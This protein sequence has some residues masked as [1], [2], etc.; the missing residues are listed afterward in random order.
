MNRDSVTLILIENQPRNTEKLPKYGYSSFIITKEE[1][2]SVAYASSAAYAV[3]E[4]GT[5]P[6]GRK[7]TYMWPFHNFWR[8][9]SS[10]N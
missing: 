8:S 6:F 9:S 1:H 3:L 5:V 7:P 2:F 4:E 10:F